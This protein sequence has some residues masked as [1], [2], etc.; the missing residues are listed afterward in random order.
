M[1]IRNMAC[2]AAVAL[3][4]LTSGALA[5]A[6]DYTFVPVTRSVKAGKEAR[7]EFR[8]LDKSKAPTVGASFIR[9]RLDMAPDGMAQHVIPVA[10]QPSAGGIYVFT[11]DLEMVGRWQL[12][13]AAKVADEPETI[14]GKL[15]I[16]VVE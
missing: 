12:S 13:L 7:V 4:V 2:W 1:S 3:L 6:A 8:L 5:G 9:T 15:I 10:I 16:T 11:A 14:V